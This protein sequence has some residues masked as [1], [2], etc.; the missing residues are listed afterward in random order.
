MVHVVDLH[1]AALGRHPP[2]E[3]PSDRDAHARLDLLLEP[4]GGARRKHPPV[5]LEQ[6][7]RH[8]VHAQDLLDALEQLVQQLVER[9]RGQRRVGDALEVSQLRRG[10]P[11]HGDGSVPCVGR[12]SRSRC[13][14]TRDVGQSEPQPA[15]PTG[16][17][18]RLSN[19]MREALHG[20]ATAFG[21]SVTI[22]A[23]FGAV[24]L[25]RGSPRFIDLIV[26][27][28]GAVLAFAGLEGL[29]SSGFRTPLAKGTDQVITLG[30]ALAFISISLAIT[31][32]DGLARAL[33]GS[34][35][36]FAGAFGASLVFVLVE[37]LEFVLAEWIQERRGEAC[38]DD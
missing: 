13:V 27:G 18:R 36:W 3:A 14:E 31:A 24:Q 28:L 32:A 34:A 15:P 38:D 19:G 6:Q 17:G 33:H 2:G 25:E 37:S 8:G 12:G 22:T 26:F 29:L 1:R 21:Y 16:V 23:S 7:H 10:V 9:E 20:N 35:A 11:G 5:V 4:L 30:T